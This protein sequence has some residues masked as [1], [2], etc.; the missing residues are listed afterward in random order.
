MNSIVLKNYS[1]MQYLNEQG[2]NPANT[3]Y[4]YLVKAISMAAFDRSY[5]HKMGQ[6]YDVV[7]EGFETRA[8]CVERAIRHSL[9]AANIDMPNRI[10]LASAVNALEM[11]EDR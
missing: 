11:Q 9:H 3:G 7:A 5:V 6:L 2:I 8:T 10:F 4:D 1:I